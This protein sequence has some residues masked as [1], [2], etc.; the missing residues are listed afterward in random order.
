M[1]QSLPPLN[2]KSIQIS[3]WA[4]LMFPVFANAANISVSP[5][6]STDGTLTISYADAPFYTGTNVQGGHNLRE[7]KDGGDWGVVHIGDGYIETIEGGEGTIE[8]GYR[9]PGTYRYRLESTRCE[10]VTGPNGGTVLQCTPTE[11]SNEASAAVIGEPG[12][13]THS[14]LSASNRSFTISWGEAS[15]PVSRYELDESVNGAAWSR[16]YSGS[17]HTY[18]GI[19][20]INNATYAYRVRSCSGAV[21]TSYTSSHSVRLPYAA[22]GTP[23]APQ[24]SVI[25]ADAI[26]A[27][28]RSSTV[29]WGVASGA[30]HKYKLWESADGGN[31]ANVY[32]NSDPETGL[33]GKLNGVT[34]RYKAQ[35]CNVDGCGNFSGVTEITLSPAPIAPSVINVPENPT[36]GIFSV[37]WS[38]SIGDVSEYQLQ[39]HEGTDPDP[40]SENW[41]EVYAGDST[42]A[43][44][45]VSGGS[46]TYRVR[47]CRATEDYL[48]CS[49]W[50]YSSAVSAV[51]PV[52][53]PMISAPPESSTGSYSVSW[54]P[55]PNAAR[56]FLQE[57]IVGGTWST[58]QDNG[59]LS[60]G[61]SDKSNNTYE[62][63][64]RACNAVGCTAFSTIKTVDVAIP[65]GVPDSITVPSLT[66]GLF[67][68]TW[69][70]ASGSATKYLLQQR[71]DDGSWTTIHDESPRNNVVVLTPMG[72]HSIP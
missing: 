58:L 3:L 22:P 69:E 54:E 41:S 39:Q 42:S 52:A 11:Y 36:D 17:G 65:P 14:N 5:S 50:R 53:A 66:D 9:A 28:M 64:V 72:I 7:S 45:T 60:L 12:T 56:Y 18:S 35:A 33:S 44:I 27:N 24:F 37:S 51:Q 55:V 61:L 26:N 63:Q 47:A 31:W 49:S 25:S 43:E 59:A 21:C 15:G 10:Y 68:V 6:V 1:F 29:N 23:G 13:P 46:Y 19:N 40:N 70:S 62:Y 71:K 20:K 4:L 67:T 38:T 32:W 48:N 2:Y 30:A 34:Y 16:V 8:V 57:R